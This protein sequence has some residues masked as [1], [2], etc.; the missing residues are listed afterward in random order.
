MYTLDDKTMT[1]E[2]ILWDDI[3]V[4]GK[5]TMSVVVQHEPTGRFYKIHATNYTHLAGIKL[6]SYKDINKSLADIPDLFKE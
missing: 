4:L 6:T 1:N 3:L 2:N 5:T